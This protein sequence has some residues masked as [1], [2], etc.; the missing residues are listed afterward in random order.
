MYSRRSQAH[1]I[2]VRSPVPCLIVIF[3]HAD[4]YLL[5]ILVHVRHRAVRIN[6]ELVVNLREIGEVRTLEIVLLNLARTLL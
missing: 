3:P 6:F 1:L 2:V 5:V 4:P